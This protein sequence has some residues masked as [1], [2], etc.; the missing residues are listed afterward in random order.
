M[1]AN[2]FDSQPDFE[3]EGVVMRGVAKAAGA[4]RPEA[5]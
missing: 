2:L 3:H 1:S 4:V 5:D